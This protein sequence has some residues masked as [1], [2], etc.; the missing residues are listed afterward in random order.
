MHRSEQ[1]IRGITDYLWDLL[2]S[3][4]LHVVAG[5]VLALYVVGVAASNRG[6]I[7]L[8]HRR[9]PD[10]EALQPLPQSLPCLLYT[11]DAADE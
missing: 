6:F 2:G 4:V 11:S 10:L 5:Q 3:R 7:P 8:F 1:G 9:T